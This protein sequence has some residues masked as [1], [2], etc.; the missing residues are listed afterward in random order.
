V[1]GITVMQ[2]AM[3]WMATVGGILVSGITVMQLV[4]AQ[5]TVVHSHAAGCK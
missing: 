4:A 1:R 5:I 2:L 3:D